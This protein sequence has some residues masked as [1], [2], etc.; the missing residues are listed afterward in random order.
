MSK[1]QS[2]IIRIVS[3]SIVA[4]VLA[5]ILVFGISGRTGWWGGF[6]F[7]FGT[8]MNYSN[9]DKYQAG[10]GE[11]DADKVKSLEINWIAGGITVQV[12]DGDTVRFSE[13]SSKTLKEKEQLHYYNDGGTLKIQYRKAG[14]TL[15][16]FGGSSLNKKLTVE[17]PQYLAE[18]LEDLS[19]DTVSGDTRIDEISARDI[20]L[21][22]TSGDFILSKCRAVNC[23]ADS[24]SGGLEADDFEVEKELEVSTTSGSLRMT[25]S[26]GKLEFDTV[27][28]DAHVESDICPE[29]VVTDSVSGS[30]TLVIPENQGFTYRKDS[31]SGSL[32]CDFN[33]KQ[34]EDRGTYKDG[35][36]SFS[37]DSV[38]GDIA[39]KRK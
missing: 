4:A 2:I 35:S 39:I 3:W 25:G 23:S 14:T 26:V 13:T 36:A 19:V 37:F 33:V 32:E 28:G 31:V 29:K 30:V 27:S 20:Q 7:S 18:E 12:Y 6:P 5:G 21:D 24:T 9:A 22:S 34:K 16:S 38:S 10:A 17:I 8:G 1:K 15:I 11:I